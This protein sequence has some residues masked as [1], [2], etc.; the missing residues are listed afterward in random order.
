MANTK[1]LYEEVST[2]SDEQLDKMIKDCAMWAAK[3][4]RLLLVAK[5]VKKHR[6]KEIGDNS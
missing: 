5:R 3:Y 1:K 6:A 2:Y 4:Q